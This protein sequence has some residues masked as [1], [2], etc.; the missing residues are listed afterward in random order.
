VSIS[1]T[2]I[3]DALMAAM[4]TRF[5]MSAESGGTATLDC[6]HHTALPTTEGLSVLL[7]EGRTVL[8][9]NIRHLEPGGVHH[10]PQK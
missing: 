7:S 2:V 9:K 5:D 10:S 1:A 3:G 8:A 6:A 4:I